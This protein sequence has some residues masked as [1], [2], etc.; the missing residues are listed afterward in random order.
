MPPQ[1][2]ITDRP[3]DEPTRHD[4]IL[5]QTN[6]RLTLNL[7]IQGAAMHTCL[8]GHHLVKDEL[9]RLRPGLTKW[10]DRLAISASLNYYIGDMILIFGTPSRFWRRIKQP[11]HPFHQHRFFTKH[12]RNLYRASKRY[13]IARA[14]KK[15]VLAIPLLHWFEMMFLFIWVAWIERGKRPELARIAEQAN[16]QIWEIEQERLH[17][18]LTTVVAFGNIKKPKTAL[19]NLIKAGAIGYGGVERRGYQF[20]IVAKAWNWPLVS[21]ELTKGTIELICLHGLGSLDDELYDRVMDDADQIEFEVWMLQA[22]AELWRRF[23]AAKPPDRSLSE[24]VMHVARLDPETL[25]H[26]MMAVVEDTER[27]RHLLEELG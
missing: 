16:S 26:L 14:W 12:G 24:T 6:K 10:Y 9:E 20:H 23:L 19:G 25:E 22:G 3:L 2:S 18:T 5:Q 21:H 15:W 4:E 11:S 1:D 27:A 8:T 17:A 7:L 13:L